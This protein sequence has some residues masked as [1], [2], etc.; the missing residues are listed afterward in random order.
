MPKD[1]VASV[2][3][4]PKWGSGNFKPLEETKEEVKLSEKV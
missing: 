4:R 3:A 1:K 2:S